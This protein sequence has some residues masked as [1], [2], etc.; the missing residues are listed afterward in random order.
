MGLNEADTRAKLIDPGLHHRGWT[1][2]HIRR[3]ETAGAV[4]IGP[5][6]KPRRRARGR[7]DYTLRVRVRA[8][9]QQRGGPQDCLY[10]DGQGFSR[11][12]RKSSWRL[13]KHCQHLSFARPSAGSCD[14][15]TIGHVAG[16]RLS[17]Y[18][19]LS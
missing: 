10:A 18:D 19:D 13:F 11:R 12:Q 9:S 3:E 15:R 16:P 8:V 7:V 1:E 5:A 2:E 17:G 14:G 4:E 6:G